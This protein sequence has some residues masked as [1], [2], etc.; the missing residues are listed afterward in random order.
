MI[1]DTASEHKYRARGMCRQRPFRDSSEAR[2]SENYLGFQLSAKRSLARSSSAKAR[3]SDAAKKPLGHRR[4]RHPRA[5]SSKNP[6]GFTDPLPT[7]SHCDK[8]LASNQARAARPGRCV[9][10][11][12]L[13][14]HSFSAKFS[15]GRHS[16]KGRWRQRNPDYKRAGKACPWEA[17]EG[18][19]RAARGTGEA[20]EMRQDV[21]G[22]TGDVITD[23]R[24]PV[25]ILDS[26]NPKSAP[27]RCIAVSI[28]RMAGTVAG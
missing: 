14:P 21:Q 16:K 5:M 9:L 12:T 1:L 10:Q 4:G 20:V 17:R 3:M 26:S 25:R 2:N 28:K 24:K 8:L 18:L 6:E 7:D 11:Y 15:I 13:R 19:T 22:K 23:R 27:Q